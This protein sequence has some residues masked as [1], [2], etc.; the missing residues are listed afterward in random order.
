M[1]STFIADSLE[2]ITAAEN[3]AREPIQI[4][5]HT[6]SYGYLVAI[7]EPDFIVRHVS[8]NI[9]SLVDKELHEIVGQNLQRLLGAHQ[10]RNVYDRLSSDD[11]MRENPISLSL[12]LAHERFDCVAHRN[13]DL[14]V[15]ELEPQIGSF[16]LG[17]INLAKHLRAP[18]ANLEAQHNIETIARV[19]AEEFQQASGFDRVI[20]YRFEP[21]WDGHVIAEIGD[22]WSSYL[23]HH[24]PAS[25]IPAQARRLFLINPLRSIVDIESTAIRIVP[26]IDPHGGR[27]LDLSYSFLRSASTVHIEY[28][29][30]MGV[31]STMTA[32]LIVKGE[33]WG[34][35]TAHHSLPHR[36]DFS[37]RSICGILAQVVS[38]EILSRGDKILLKDQLKS[39]IRIESYMTSIENAANTRRGEP[40]ETAPLLELLR[41]DGVMSLV[42]GIASG[43]GIV[44]D[45]EQIKP[46]V[47]LLRKKASRGI[48]SSTML[49]S[50]DP[51]AAA[52]ADRASGA[53]YIG[54]TEKTEDYILVLR[55]EA[56]QTIV[57]AGNPT[58]I[59]DHGMPNHGLSPRTS[60]DSWHETVRGRSKPWTD[61]EIEKAQILREQFVNARLNRHLQERTILYEEERTRSTLFQQAVLPPALPIVPGLTFDAIYESGLSD[62]QI[63]GDWYDAVRLLDGRVLL[64]I[65]DVAGHGIGAAVIMGVVRQIMRGI[66]QLHAEP[67][68]MLDA[69]DRALRLEYPDA[70]V[71]AWV[72]VFD[73]VDRTLTYASAGHP[74]PLLLD[75]KTDIRELDHRTLP[76]GLRQGHQG[77][78]STI[79]IA[80][81]NLLCLY[82]DGIIEA[83]HNILDGIQRLRQTILRLGRS[84]VSHPAATIRRNV[85]PNGSPDDVAILVAKIDLNA[86]ERNLTRSHFESNN[87]FA[88]GKARRGFAASLLPDKFSENDIANAEIV[89]GELCGNV[90][91]YAPGRVDIIV[92]RSGLQTVLHV[93]DHGVGFR[94]LSRLPADPLA[95]HGRGLFIIASM[96]AEFTVTQRIG[97]GSHARAVLIGR[98]PHSLLIEETLPAIS[99]QV[100]ASF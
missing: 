17:P 37:T 48:A 87:G 10:F 44:V 7:S 26:E 64:T 60:F 59:I 92:D 20:V 81:G 89:F 27:P 4:I 19:A 67:A 50:I 74:P 22:G 43:S 18:M 35:I 62:E 55:K 16:S 56:I 65:G 96:T 51:N 97:G 3:C 75:G 1:R 25:D 49:S 79:S 70:F 91:R 11:L 12:G 33:L 38:A 72:G 24:F 90:A 71:T 45:Q 99:D 14:L 21:N 57:W 8:E 94:H 53:L 54:L 82:T 46:V 52:F 23:D 28:L 9:L 58:K 40:L 78:A 100:P 69:A 84:R 76:I 39:R 34:M 47:A 95:E 2:Q 41:A 83:T 6:Q 66:A 5:A 63:G 80:H 86:V 30:N 31:R 98:Y 32:S 36:L 13:T 61:I 29:H 42:D 93:L 88:A 15:L 68:L 77:H 85:I 73:L